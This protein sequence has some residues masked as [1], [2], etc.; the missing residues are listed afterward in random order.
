MIRSNVAKLFNRQVTKRIDRLISEYAEY[1]AFL[2]Q[3]HGD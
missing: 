3:T 1:A 2:M